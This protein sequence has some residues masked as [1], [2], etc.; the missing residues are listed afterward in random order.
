MKR[1]NRRLAVCPGAL[2]G[3]AGTAPADPLNVTDFPSLGAFPTAAGTY[4]VNTS[5]T[6]TLTGPGG[7]A[8]TGVVSGDIAVFTFDSITV[9]S[10]MMLTGTGTRPVALLSYGDVAVRGTGLVD[11]GGRTPAGAPA[12]A[13]AA[14]AAAV[15]AAAKGS[16][17]SC[18]R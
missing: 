6:P 15:P 16:E 2:G 4:T 18:T 11:V 10:G 3:T 14:P 13:A 1:L 5:G 8:I 9:G 17:S 12:V 7:T